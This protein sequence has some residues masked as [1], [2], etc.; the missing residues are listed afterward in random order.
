MDGFYRFL[1]FQQGK[2]M[3]T[4]HWTFIFHFIAP[5]FELADNLL[6]VHFITT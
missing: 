6:P 2:G 4:N 3:K 5:S 1:I